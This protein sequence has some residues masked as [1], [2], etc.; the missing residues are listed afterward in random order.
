MPD[1][2]TMTANFEN[3]IKQHELLIHKVCR[4]Y[5]RSPDDRKDLFQEI[6][7]QLWKA[8][9]R[10]R[11]EAKLSTWMYRVSLNTAIT[12]LR[13]QKATIELLTADMMPEIPAP[14][15][16]ARWREMYM[17]IEQLNHIE[18]AI[19]MLYLDDRSYN[20]MEEIIGISTG[21][22]RVKM[23]RI[24]KKLRLLIKNT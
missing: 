8:Y 5:A 15:D 16:E 1:K 12:H 22:I 20:E 21:A 18:K 2:E 9:P 14:E 7:I 13:R 3:Y 10:F 19:V 17:A 24:K 23:S 11:G 4:V 6:V